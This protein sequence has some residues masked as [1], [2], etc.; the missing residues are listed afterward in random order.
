MQVIGSQKLILC[1]LIILIYFRFNL[2]LGIA[3]MCYSI[4]CLL[5]CLSMC[6]YKHFKRVDISASLPDLK[7]P[8]SDYLPT[9]LIAEANKEVLK[10][11]AGA[12]EQQ[13]KGPYITVTPE[14]K[15]KVTMFASINGNSYSKRIMVAA[16]VM[17][18]VQHFSNRTGLPNILVNVIF[19]YHRVRCKGFY[20]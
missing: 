8:L 12:K 15:A 6:L 20:F 3:Y 19:P 13:K 17:V 1:T 18:A 14:H 7:G 4:N 5:D 10:A 9:V 16:Y 2:M 11:V